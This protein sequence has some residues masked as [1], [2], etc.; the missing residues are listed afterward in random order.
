MR[1]AHGALLS[2]LCLAAMTSA[3]AAAMKCQHSTVSLCD[4]CSTSATWNVVLAPKGPEAAR[5]FCY[6][7]WRSLGGSQRFEVVKSPQLG[8][9]RTHD[10]RLAYRG[11][12][13]G[14]DVVVLKQSWLSPTNRTMTGTVTYTINVVPSL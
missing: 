8:T 10:Y 1:L 9:L 11:E 3:A 14:R 13:V 2:I 5:A 4:G 6:F 12:K 7:D